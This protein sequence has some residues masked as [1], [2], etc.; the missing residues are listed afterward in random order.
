MLGFIYH[1]EEIM[2]III[3]FLQSSNGDA[4]DLFTI[5]CAI[6]IDL[7]FKIVKVDEN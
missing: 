7:K 6:V 2:D 1:P 3:R 5:P 4:L